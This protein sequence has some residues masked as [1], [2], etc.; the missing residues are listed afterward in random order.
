M[1]KEPWMDR[2][3]FI[4]K[5]MQTCLFCCGAAL[6]LG[7]S[8]QNKKGKSVSDTTSATDQQWIGDLE[9][10]M[11]QG[12]ET[13]GWRKAE[14]C[15]QWIKNL[16]DHLDA[17]IDEKTRIQLMQACGHSCYIG[18][19]GVAPEKKPTAEE[20]RTFLDHIKKAGFDIRREGNTTTF[21]YRW[22]RD[23]QNPQGLIMKDG[24]C[25]C[26][27][28]ESGPPGLSPTFCYCSTGYVRESFQRKIDKP[29]HV[30]LLDSLKR[31]GKDCIFKIIIKD[32]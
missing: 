22:G 32:T 29:V 4:K 27:L 31:G 18:A 6:S 23:H 14:K 3:Q 26:P 12:A 30:A 5:S 11:I 13:P 21:I 1:G 7:N 9:K 19:F 28:V 15:E 24:Y 17:L 8:L 2:K 16:M 10:R 20:T 25:M